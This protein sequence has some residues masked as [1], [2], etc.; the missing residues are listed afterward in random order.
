MQSM[1][2]FL[3]KLLVVVGEMDQRPDASV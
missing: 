3:C 2:F 1:S